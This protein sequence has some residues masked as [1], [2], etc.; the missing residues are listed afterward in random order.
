MVTSY[1]V[2]EYFFFNSYYFK[3]KGDILFLSKSDMRRTFVSHCS[4][5]W[6]LVCFNDEKATVYAVRRKALFSN[7]L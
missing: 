5:A 6:I 4:F 3:I 1:G 7:C 2:M